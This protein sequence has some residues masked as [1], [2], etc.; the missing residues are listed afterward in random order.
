MRTRALRPAGPPKLPDTAVVTFLG[1]GLHGGEAFSRGVRTLQALRETAQSEPWT[2]ADLNR[3]VRKGHASVG[4]LDVV[5][6]DAPPWTN[7]QVRRLGARH[8]FAV[9]RPQLEILPKPY[10]MGPLVEAGLPMAG[11]SL[12]AQHVQTPML[13]WPDTDPSDGELRSSQTF[14]GMLTYGTLAAKADPPRKLALGGPDV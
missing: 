4:V 10:R 7:T 8:T 11:N 2:W 9:G 13:P 6:G 3:H 12:Q 1:T 5:S 14:P